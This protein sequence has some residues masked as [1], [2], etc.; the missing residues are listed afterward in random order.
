MSM[1]HFRIEDA[2]TLLWQ[3]PPRS[4]RAQEDVHPFI[5]LHTS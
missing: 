1:T 4:L 3:T 2:L 5:R